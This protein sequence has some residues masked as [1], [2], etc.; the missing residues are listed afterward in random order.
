MITRLVWFGLVFT[1]AS[2]DDEKTNHTHHQPIYLSLTESQE[3]QRNHSFDRS[4]DQSIGPGFFVVSK[5]NGS[6]FLFLRHFVPV[7]VFAWQIVDIE[8]VVPRHLRVT[9]YQSVILGAAVQ[10]PPPVIVVIHEVF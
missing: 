1:I 10:F 9:Q 7:P 5:M 3:I 2:V 6:G 8:I 4:I